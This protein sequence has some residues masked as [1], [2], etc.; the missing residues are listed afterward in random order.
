MDDL[1]TT[2]TVAAVA[3]LDLAREA[4]DKGDLQRAQV[5]ALLGIGGALVDLAVK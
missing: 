3:H 4:L 2:P 5:L 1:M